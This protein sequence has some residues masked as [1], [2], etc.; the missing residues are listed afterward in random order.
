MFANPS[1]ISPEHIAIIMDGNRRWAKKH[2]TSTIAGH[3]AGVQAIHTLIE[4]A[5]T[6]KISN[7]TLFA[8]SSENWQRD[9]NDVSNLMKLMSSALT[10]ESNKILEKN[11]RL[12][13]I[14]DT[15]RFG[16]KIMRQISDVEHKSAANTGIT[17]AV[18]MNYGGRWDITNA[19]ASLVADVQAGV[20]AAADINEDLLASYMCLADM[21]AVDL[22]IRPGGEQRIS[23]FLLWQVAY[24]EL[25]FTATLWPDF[26]SADL[27]AAVEWFSKRERRFGT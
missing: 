9:K 22:L 15:E 19:T 18:C 4:T 26:S 3:K 20:V 16:K 24:A 25:Y 21:P 6:L 17:L 7:I 27:L 8:F 1:M 14:G 11:V 12:K 2:N 23:N 10:T 5:K 13:I